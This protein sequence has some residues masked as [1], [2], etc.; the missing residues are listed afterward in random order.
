M[1]SQPG[2]EAEKD[3]LLIRVTELNQYLMQRIERLE[4]IEAEYAER[5][6]IGTQIAK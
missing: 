4:V 6:K 5:L 1:I 2:R 3:S